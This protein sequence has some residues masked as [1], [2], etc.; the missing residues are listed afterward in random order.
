MEVNTQN[1]KRVDLVTVSGR[2]DSSNAPQLDEALKNLTNSGRSNLVLDLSQVDYMSS[3]G[4]RSLVSTLRDCKRK[5]G[6]VRLATPSPRVS[7]VLSLA[8]LDSIFEVYDN[9]TEAVGSF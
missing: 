8:G 5:G 9:T 3:A 1:F 6:D 4:L 2:V 7:D